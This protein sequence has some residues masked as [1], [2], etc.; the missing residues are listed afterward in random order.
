MTKE[1]GLR[2]IASEIPEPDDGDAGFPTPCLSQKNKRGRVVGRVASSGGG[3][4]NHRSFPRGPSSFNSMSKLETRG[5]SRPEEPVPVVT[6]ILGRKIDKTS[7]KRGS[8]C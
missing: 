5:K 7:A 2:N 1:T 4:A 6:E 8:G 3:W